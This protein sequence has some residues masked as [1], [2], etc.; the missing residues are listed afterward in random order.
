VTERSRRL[1]EDARGIWS[2]NVQIGA[3]GLVGVGFFAGSS[4]KDNEKKN[5]KGQRLSRMVHI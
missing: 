4:T 1:D 3:R 5:G 2:I